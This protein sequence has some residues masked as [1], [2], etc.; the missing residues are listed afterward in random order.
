MIRVMR[1][2]RYRCAY[3]ASPHPPQGGFGRPLKHNAER[4]CA[5]GRLVGT[6]RRDQNH[7]AGRPTVR[8]AAPRIIC[9]MF[10][11]PPQRARD[12]PRALTRTDPPRTL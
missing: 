9:A 5:V 6:A 3:T 12:R 8:A 11:W 1:E 4:L 7:L 2:G 10:K